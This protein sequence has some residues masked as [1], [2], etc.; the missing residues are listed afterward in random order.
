MINIVYFILGF[1]FVA[2]VFNV[3][4]IVCLVRER[5]NVDRIAKRLRRLK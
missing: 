2:I 3:M 5:H 1:I 4:I